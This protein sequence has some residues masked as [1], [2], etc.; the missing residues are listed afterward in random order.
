MEAFEVSS[1]RHEGGW[2]CV[3]FCTQIGF[4]GQLVLLYLHMKKV[5]KMKIESFLCLL[6]LWMLLYFLMVLI[7]FYRKF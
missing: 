7:F 1:R 2:S 5:L 6:S 4:Y 3:G